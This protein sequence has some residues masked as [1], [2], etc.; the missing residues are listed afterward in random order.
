VIILLFIFDTRLSRFQDFLYR[1]LRVR[2]YG[3]R[4]VRTEKISGSFD[5]PIP[6]FC[7]SGLF[8]LLKVMAITK[9][10]IPKFGSEVTMGVFLIQVM[11]VRADIMD[12][13]GRQGVL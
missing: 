4:F 1:F 10:G 8:P 2:F 7:F 5:Y 9:I 6:H 3:R 13:V 11:T 12:R